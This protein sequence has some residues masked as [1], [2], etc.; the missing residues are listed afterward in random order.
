MFQ[1]RDAAEHKATEKV[2]TR[3]Y[4]TEAARKSA[5][6]QIANRTER[7]IDEWTRQNVGLN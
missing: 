4:K 7:E 1:N 6:T 2:R 5:T 3:E